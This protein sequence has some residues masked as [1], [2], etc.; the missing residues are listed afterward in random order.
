MP[1]SAA[2]QQL[3]PHAAPSPHPLTS[4]HHHHT[5]IATS[6]LL[7]R[8]WEAVS[9][10]IVAEGTP[11][12]PDQLK[13]LAR[14][15]AA[16]ITVTWLQVRTLTVLSPFLFPPR[17]QYLMWAPMTGQGL[18]RCLPL[19]ASTHSSACTLTHLP[20]ASCAPPLSPV[21]TQVTSAV[22]APC[23]RLTKCLSQ[24]KD[25]MIVLET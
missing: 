21:C 6:G 2:S 16:T 7:K 15:L 13:E 3:E 19:H 5:I 12:L 1:S 22:S 17:L 18:A 9:L 23:R 24:Q 11:G 25:E 10:R 20:V 4:R 8:G 14:C